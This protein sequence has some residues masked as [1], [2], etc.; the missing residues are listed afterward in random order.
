MMSEKSRTPS[1]PSEKRTHRR[2]PSSA[3]TRSTS[4][5]GQS[6]VVI[7]AS[8][9]FQR[10]VHKSTL[11]IILQFRL[12]RQS[13]LTDHPCRRRRQSPRNN[14]AGGEPNHVFGPAVAR[15]E[16]WRRMVVVMHLNQ[17]AVEPRNCRHE[18]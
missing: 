9:F 5:M 16:M 6:F 4:T 8:N 15:V 1:L 14:S 11:P 2:W 17:Y 7:G 13:P 12:S 3:L 18:L 10:L